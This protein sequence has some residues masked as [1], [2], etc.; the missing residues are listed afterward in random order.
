M[1]VHVRVQAYTVGARLDAPW[2]GPSFLLVFLAF[3]LF[4]RSR[5]TL[6][7]GRVSLGTLLCHPSFVSFPTSHFNPNPFLVTARDDKDLGIGTHV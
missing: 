4:Q 6:Y 7:P 1:C 2:L 3:L 5:L